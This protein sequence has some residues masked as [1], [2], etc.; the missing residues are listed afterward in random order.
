MHHSE[1]GASLPSQG[2]LFLSSGKALYV[3]Q[4][5]PTEFHAHH[6]FQTVITHER[7]LAFRL[8]RSHP[9][10][11][12]FSLIV[13]PGVPHHIDT[14]QQLSVFVWVE[15]ESPAGRRFFRLLGTDQIYTDT[16]QNGFLPP[17]TELWPRVQEILIA[18]QKEAVHWLI[19]QLL[20]SAEIPPVTRDSRIETILNILQR[21]PFAMQTTSLIHFA[22]L[23]ALSPHRLR[24][25]F[26]EQVGLSFYRYLLWRRLVT[27]LLLSSHTG[28]LT[29]AAHQAGFAD[30][31]HFSRTVRAMLGIKPSDLFRDSHFI[32]VHPLTDKYD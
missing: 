13:K 25:L 23:V 21:E 29:I 30:S 18:P 26:V 31:A 16:S 10:E 12:T 17:T 8:D 19:E 1:Q 15:P 5:F 20:P 28:S 27:A 7:P 2:R 3:G 11:T 32:Q 4:G 9:Y 14:Q 22:N 24:H 6:A